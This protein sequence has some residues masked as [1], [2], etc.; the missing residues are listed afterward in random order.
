MSLEDYQ[1]AG[2]IA[3]E[4]L[5]YGRELIRKDARIV[6]V[7]NKVEEEV[8]RLGGNL[9]FPVQISCNEIA[10]HFCPPEDDETVFSDQLVNLDVGVHVNGFIGDY[11]CCVDLV[12]NRDFV[13]AAEDALGAATEILAVGVPLWKIGKEIENAIGNFG[14]KPVR[15]LSGHGLGAYNIHSSPQIPN[16]NNNDQT[17]LAKGMTIAIEP[18]ATDGL[19]MVHEKGNATIFSLTGRKPVRIGFVRDIQK[20]IEGFNGLPFTTRWLNSKFS[21]EKV[22]FALNQF[23]QLGIIHEYPPLVE[24]TNCLVSQAENSFYI[25]DEVVCLTKK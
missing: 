6:D 24:R 23:R 11:A 20:E 18:F 16:Y 3:R 10:A 7:C 9:A 17:T 13:K 19:G 21:K 12:H 4:A 8:H 14:L 5:E 1:K 25:D 22:T 2:K 15:N